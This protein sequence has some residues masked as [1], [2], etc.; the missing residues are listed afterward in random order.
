MLLVLAA[1]L[2]IAQAPGEESWHV[3]RLNR[4]LVHDLL[5][6]VQGIQLSPDGA[7]VLYRVFG[8]GTELHC[9]PA[10]GSA[11]PVRVALHPSSPIDDRRFSPDGQWVVYLTNRLNSVRIDGT[12]AHVLSPNGGGAIQDFLV[13]PDSAWVVFTRGDNPDAVFS[14][15]ID[16]SLP[17]VQLSDPPSG[18]VL[19]EFQITPD[20]AAVVYNMSGTRFQE[21]LFRAPIDGSA[22]PMLLAQ[23]AGTGRVTDFEVAPAGGQVV[24]EVGFGD[25]LYSTPLAGGA[26]TLLADPVDEVT[27]LRVSPDGQW[28]VYRADR[29]Y[30]V[31]VTGGASTPLTA[32]SAAS[33]YLITPDSTRVVYRS[34][35]LDSVP[36]GGGA[37]T[38]LLDG[39]Q[40]GAVFALTADGS[41]VVSTLSDFMSELWSVPTLGGT[42]VEIGQDSFFG[43]S[44]FA[45]D[46]VGD[47][48]LFDARDISP[49][50]RELWSAPV[51]GSQAP[52]R[53]SPEQVGQRGASLGYLAH[54]GHAFYVGDFDFPDG[55]QLYRAPLD[56]SQA[57]AILNAPLPESD[58]IL[59]DVQTYVVSPRG[60]RVAYMADQRVDDVDSAFSVS[61][62]GGPVSELAEAMQPVHV[63]PDGR[64]AVLLG[65]SG[66]QLHYLSAP[67]D[68]GQPA[69]DLTP[70]EFVGFPARLDPTGTWLAYPQQGRVHVVPVDGSAPSVR[71]DSPDIV[72]RGIGNGEGRIE[73][74]PDG[75]R[76]VF[77]A[78]QMLS[79]NSVRFHLFSAPIDGSQAPTRLHSGPPISGAVHHFQ[80]SPD[81]TRVVFSAHFGTPQPAELYSVPIDGSAPPVRINLP[82]LPESDVLYHAPSAGQEFQIS[83]DGRVVAYVAGRV[84]GDPFQLYVVP[85]DG[86]GGG[87]RLNGA[88]P[89]GGDVTAF[90]PWFDEQFFIPHAQALFRFTPDGTRV[91]Y[92][93]DQRIDGRP[94]LYSVAVP[95]I[96]D[97]RLRQV[98]A[99]RSVRVGHPLGPFEAVTHLELAAEGQVVYSVG[100]LGQGDGELYRAPVEGGSSVRVSDAM[101]PGQGLTGSGISFA[102]SPDGRSAV[103][104]ADAAVN[105][106]Y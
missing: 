70:G 84:Q 83:P 106:R 29:L 33:D 20:S 46:P 92:V 100:L 52:V 12:D 54:S 49:S 68:G 19:G 58:T 60:D 22:S 74:S 44:S 3:R 69:T 26:Q 99:P 24:Y 59:G 53:V 94:E 76:V 103:Y 51:D 105:G 64:T 4:P 8:A 16:G 15:P 17:A 23:P 73:I 2:L 38:V 50:E 41:R 18:L 90:D 79:S 61:S 36:I 9:G 97:R 71:L 78:D 40:F 6:D 102:L 82:L 80:I 55:F 28:L 21:D 7:T 96:L 65:F 25:Q 91:L 37:P 56:A 85:I 81:S 101:P 10:D 1:S 5:G 13:S 89:A 27:T 72:G 88:L 30:G 39:V 86:S 87:A 34:A 32:G 42:A 66:G 45:L 95:P 98:P 14:V 104:L 43:V 11:Q 75:N 57:P 67:I 35:T 47:R 31:P 62:R 93:A 48:V 77:V 63:T